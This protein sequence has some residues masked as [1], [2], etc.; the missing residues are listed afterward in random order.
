MEWVKQNLKFVIGMVVS[1]LLIGGAGYFAYTQ[2]NAYSAA[3]NNLSS[4]RG[5][6]ESL[7]QETPHPGTETIRNIDAASKDL[8]NNVQVLYDRTVSLFQPVPDILL[9]NATDLNI[10]VNEGIYRMTVAD[11]TWTDCL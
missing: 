6:W 2:Y 11:R 8:T 9:T 1:I 4:V 3:Q 7:E 5:S 10:A